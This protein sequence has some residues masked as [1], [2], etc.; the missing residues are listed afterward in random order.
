MNSDFFFFL[1]FVSRTFTN[2][3]TAG[4]GGGHFF[5]PSLPLPHPL[6]RT[7]ILAGRLLQRKSISKSINRKSNSSRLGVLTKNSDIISTILHISKCT[8][9]NTHLEHSDLLANYGNK[10]CSAYHIYYALNYFT[11]QKEYY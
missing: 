5:N 4:E 3:R 9:F 10:V 6:H 8:T 2:H 11:Y 7:Y 1:G